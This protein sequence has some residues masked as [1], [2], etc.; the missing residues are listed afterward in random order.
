MGK[1]HYLCENLAVWE[2]YT[3]Y[4]VEDDIIADE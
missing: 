1:N 4:F 2:L 3:K